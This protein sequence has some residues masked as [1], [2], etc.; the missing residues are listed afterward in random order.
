[1][2]SNSWTRMRVSVASAACIEEHDLRQQCLPH[3]VIGP[4]TLVY[5]RVYALIALVFRLAECQTVLTRS[6]ITFHQ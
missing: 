3:T 2:E 4:R 5:L 1:M 6:R